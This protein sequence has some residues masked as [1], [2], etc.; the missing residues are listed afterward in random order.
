MIVVT[1]AS[2]NVGRP[3]VHALV[4]AGEKVSAVSRRLTA[5]DVRR[6]QNFGRRI[7]LGR[8]ISHRP[9]TALTRCS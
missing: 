2:G 4:E 8:T 1:G 7:S 6:E 5:A 3:L 9:S